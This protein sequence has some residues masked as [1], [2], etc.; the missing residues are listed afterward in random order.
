M[1]LHANV[2]VGHVEIDPAFERI[3][4]PFGVHILLVLAYI[5]ITKCTKKN[6]TRNLVTGIQRTS[7]IYTQLSPL[8]PPIASTNPLDL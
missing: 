8:R 4:V 6:N 3:R 2:V 1:S 5:F 7:D